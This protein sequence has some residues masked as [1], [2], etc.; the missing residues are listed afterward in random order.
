MGNMISQQQMPCRACGQKGKTLLKRCNNCQGEGS[1]KEST[2]LEVRVPQ[3]AREGQSVLFPSMGDSPTYNSLAGDV[4]VEFKEKPHDVFTRKGHHLFI[5]QKITLAQ[6]LL[7]FTT[8][9]KHL[10]GHEVEIKSTSVI[11]PGQTLCVVE[12]GLMHSF[13]PGRG[14]DQGNLYVTFDIEFPTDQVMNQIKSNPQATMM[15]QQLLQGP[16]HLNPNP[17]PNTKPDQPRTILTT[18]DAEQERFAREE[19]Q[20][21]VFKQQQE[22]EHARSSQGANHDDDEGEIHVSSGPACQQM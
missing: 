13:G 2:T 4:I 19:K 9:I 14:V 20:W 18:L 22:Q 5:K 6:A 21:K 15:M 3:G 11:R 10:D 7:G 17:T 1:T 16:N 8:Y 12:Q